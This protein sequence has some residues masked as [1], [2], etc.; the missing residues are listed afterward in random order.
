MFKA[1]QN[2]YL[3]G[4]NLGFRRIYK[5]NLMRGTFTSGTDRKKDY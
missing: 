2:N 1:E 5:R 3:L 4:Y